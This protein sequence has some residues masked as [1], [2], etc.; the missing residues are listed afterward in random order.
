MV[1]EMHYYSAC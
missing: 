1:S